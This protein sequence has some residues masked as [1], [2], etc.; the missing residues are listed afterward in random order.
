VIEHDL[1]HGATIQRSSRSCNRCHIGAR[2]LGSEEVVGVASI[3]INPRVSRFRDTCNV[4]VLRSGTE[5]ILVDFGDGD[6]LDHLEE[7]GVERVTDVL[8]THHHRDQL[9]GLQR[10]VDAGIRVW[11]PPS[12]V[13]LIAGMDERWQRRQVAN[14]Y[15]LREDRFS[16]LRSVPVTGAVDEYRT[17]RFGDLAV[18]ALPTPGHTLGSVTYLVE[19]EG[20]RLAFT[21]DLVYGDGK[22]WSL[23]ATQ[24][25]YSGLEGW[26][27]TIISASVLA[28]RDPAVLLP[29]HGDPILEPATA[30]AKL[31]QRMQGLIDLRDPRRWNV[32]ERLRMPFDPITPHLLRN[33]TVFATSYVLL[34]ETGAALVIDFGYD[35][36]T[37]ADST[38]RAARRTLLWSLDGLRRDYGVERI[39]AA[40]VTH[41]HDDHVAG[42][43]LL[44]DVEAAEVWAPENVA[45]ILEEPSRYDL[46][47]LWFDPIPVDR[48][49]PFEQPIQWHEHELTVYPLPGHTR[50]AA[51]ISFEV[52]GTRILVTGDQQTDDGARSIL[53][54]QYR[55]RFLPE[56]FVASAQLYRRLQPD[57]LLGGHWLPL[58]VTDDLLLR[59]G[60]DAERLGE[61]HRELLPDEGFGTA[62]FGARIEPY[63][64]SPGTTEFTVHVRNPFEREQAATVRFAGEE[65][66]VDL[67]PNGE[68]A[69]TFTVTSAGPRR[70]AAEL[71]V[72][73]TRFGQQ[74]EALV[75]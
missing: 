54:Y 57:L 39:D 53:N 7:L 42:L 69:V 15:D 35:V 44:R 26:G 10:A 34:S 58:A 30:L 66:T 49:I 21:G 61:L 75:E 11:A 62:G 28:D 23:A 36:T 50:Y 27:A 25:T 71:T 56:D 31:A 32:A 20:Q 8:L 13:E 9:G 70:L 17:T 16:L 24:W 38:E 65:R 22:V 43:N 37:T 55:N 6:V 18:Y 47:C 52:D 5:A 48:V 63:R 2:R 60:S 72:G 14:D 29:S 51:A 74:A 73:G 33:R 41:Y 3:S 45:P 64:S 1:A 67:E 46:P 19:V 12:E 4:Y 68:A 59:L 40:I